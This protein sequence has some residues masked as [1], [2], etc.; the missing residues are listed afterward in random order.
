[1]K[2]DE[3]QFF[4][5]MPI[6]FHLRQ[7]PIGPGDLIRDASARHEIGIRDYGLLN[8]IRQVPAICDALHPTTQMLKRHLK[9]SPSEHRRPEIPMGRGLGARL[10][11]RRGPVF[12]GKAGCRGG[13]KEHTL[14][15]SVT[16]EQRSQ[17]AFPAKTLRAMGL[18]REAFVGSTVTAR[19]GDAPVS[20]SRPRTKSLVAGPFLILRRALR[21]TS[22][23]MRGLRERTHAAR[24]LTSNRSNREYSQWCGWRKAVRVWMAFPVVLRSLPFYTAHVKRDSPSGSSNRFNDPG[25]LHLVGR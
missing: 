2:S 8:A 23:G 16:E 4:G 12:A 3:R 19:C 10:K 14:Q 5:A 9:R 15:G 1:M 11:T 18:L 20:P 21:P 7:D 25:S 6:H 17:A 24:A 13:T 22:R